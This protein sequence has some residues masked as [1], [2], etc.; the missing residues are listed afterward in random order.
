MQVKLVCI[1]DNSYCVVLLDWNRKLWFQ[2]LKR[3][4]AIIAWL[5][6]AVPHRLACTTNG[7]VNCVYSRDRFD[8]SVSCPSPPG[9][10]RL[11]RSSAVRSK[12]AERKLR[13]WAPRTLEI[14]LASFPRRRSYDMPPN[15]ALGFLWP[16][17]I[18]DA[19]VMFLLCFFLL[20]S[21]PN[22]SGRIEW[23][24]TILPHMVCGPNANL[25]CRSEMCCK[26]LAENLS[27]IHISEPTRPY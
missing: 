15:L 14:G 25:E 18:A 4:N 11:R 24:S 23:M 17:C 21:S 5:W 10:T 27:L 1:G 7:T 16:P 22:L 2:T 13:V 20:F 9:A 12:R 26:R 6:F 3:V 8:C 19:D